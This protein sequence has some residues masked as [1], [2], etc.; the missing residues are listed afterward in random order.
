MDCRLVQSGTGWFSLVQ[1]G[2][3]LWV[4]QKPQSMVGP[5]LS[6]CPVCQVRGPI[7]RN[8]KMEGQSDLRHYGVLFKEPAVA[9]A[10]TQ[11]L[12]RSTV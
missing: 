12:P 7:P 3:V 4:E 11:S 9:V 5:E 2:C 1:A 10:A 8:W 6:C